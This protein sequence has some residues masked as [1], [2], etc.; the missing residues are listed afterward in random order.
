MDP[1]PSEASK[2]TQ[3]QWGTYT[4]SRLNTRGPRDRPVRPVAGKLSSC[5]VFPLFWYLATSAHLFLRAYCVQ[6][7][8]FL[9]VVIYPTDWTQERPCSGLGDKSLSFL[10]NF[11]GF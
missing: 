10:Q 11:L 2:A 8:M 1:G 9:P 6:T 3:G 5:D 7:L 4:E